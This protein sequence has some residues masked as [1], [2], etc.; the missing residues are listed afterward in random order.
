MH[1]EVVT[2]SDEE[3]RT[4]MTATTRSGDMAASYFIS[5]RQPWERAVWKQRFNCSLAA[6]NEV[7]SAVGRSVSEVELEFGRRRAPVARMMG[8]P[9]KLRA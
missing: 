7:I 9:P 6:L 5:L 3:W 2:A 8:R 4:T 1:D